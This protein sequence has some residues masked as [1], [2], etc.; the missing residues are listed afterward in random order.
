VSAPGVDAAVSVD[1]IEE[2]GQAGDEVDQ[3]E[4]P[5][6]R[7]LLPAVRPGANRARGQAEQPREL[8]VGDLE[9]GGTFEDRGPA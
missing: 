5:D 3:G 6:Q 2:A 4:L 8:T 1:L 9:Q 7:D